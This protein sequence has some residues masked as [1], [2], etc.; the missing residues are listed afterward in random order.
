M[1]N[2]NWTL[3]FLPTGKT[4]VGCKWVFRVKENHDGYVNK[5][6]ARLVDKGYLQKYG[7]DYTE[8]FSPFVK[9]ITMRIILPL[10]S[11]IISL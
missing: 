4:V 3:T 6:K 8:T 10:P 5:Y 2:N 11:Q 7:C 9:P 1:T